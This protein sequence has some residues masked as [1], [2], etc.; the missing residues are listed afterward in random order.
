MQTSL[1]PF[2]C[3]LA[4]INICQTQSTRVRLRALARRLRQIGENIRLVPGN[5]GR[6]G[7]RKSVFFPSRH[8]SIRPFAV[9][10]RGL[11]HRA[12]TGIGFV[13]PMRGSNRQEHPCEA[14]E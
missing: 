10:T 11:Q 3:S 9:K 8:F 7:V 1:A 5:A 12:T 13:T 14:S 6:A 4:I 2:F